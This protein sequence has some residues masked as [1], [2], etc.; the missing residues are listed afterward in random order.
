MQQHDVVSGIERI[1]K[2]M[3]MS[4]GPNDVRVPVSVFD[5]VMKT[6]NYVMDNWCDYDVA[7]DPNHVIIAYVKGRDANS[8][9]WFTREF[10]DRI[11]FQG[12]TNA[13]REEVARARFAVGERPT[14]SSGVDGGYT[15]GYGILD[16]NGYWEYPLHPAASYIEMLVQHASEGPKSYK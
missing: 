3:S 4:P 7:R 16:D 6:I 5:D 9:I 2:L 10:A 11:K 12:L 15:C 13:Q 1:P 8:E 14:F